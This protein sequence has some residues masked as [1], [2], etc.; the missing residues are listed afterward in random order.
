[1]KRLLLSLMVAGGVAA[2]QAP[3]AQAE[4]LRDALAAAYANNPTL[5]AARAQLRATD[6]LV[7]QALAGRRPGVSAFANAGKASTS[8]NGGDASN[9]TPRSIGIQIDQP[10]WT[11]GRV[12]ASVSSAENQILAQRASLRGTEQDVLLQGATAYGDVFRD[13]A[14]LELSINNVRVLERQLQATRDRFEVGEV[15]RTDVAQAEAR[16]AIAEAERTRAEAALAASRAAYENVV[17][18]MPGTLVEPAAFAQLPGSRGDAQALSR[19]QNPN[20][21]AARFAEAAARSEV[22]RAKAERWPS[23][24][25]TASHSRD[26]DSSTLINRTEDTR[27]VANLTVPLYQAGAEYSGIRQTKQV[28]VQRRNE[29]SR[30]ERDVLEA[31]TSSWE[32]LLATRAQIQSLEA[33]V[34]AAEIALEGVREEASVGARTTLD[35][36]DAEQELFGA[37][38]DLVGARRDYI[39]ASFQVANAVGRLDAATLEL[40]VDEYDVE[41]N[42]REVRDAYWGTGPAETR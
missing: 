11:G 23:I 26:H 19:E 25:V 2:I 16:L 8:A 36:L 1:M 18:E 40:P 20:V 22:D 3:A 17:G 9:L 41:R 37:R 4:T 39:V 5:Q 12:D 34:R 27:I 24:D 14:V 38:V 28:A 21:R 30:A 29:L 13:Q 32:N 10:L 35:V 42:Y 15:T 7:P 31:A 6:E 33:A